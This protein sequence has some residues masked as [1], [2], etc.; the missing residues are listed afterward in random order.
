MRALDRWRGQGRIEWRRRSRALFNSTFEGR[1]GPQ[2]LKERNSWDTPP[3]QGNHFH[4]GLSGSL[5]FSATGFLRPSKMPCWGYCYLSSADSG[6]RDSDKTAG[7]LCWSY[8]S[9]SASL[10]SYLSCSSTGDPRRPSSLAPA[11]QQSKFASSGETRSGGAY[12]SSSDPAPASQPCWI[13]CK[14]PCWAS[15]HFDPGYF[16]H[17]ELF[18]DPT[19]QAPSHSSSQFTG[20]FQFSDH[21]L[22]Q[23]SRRLSSCCGGWLSTSHHLIRRSPRSFS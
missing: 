10:R 7:S 1:N 2:F 13:L 20:T 18:A 15:W 11:S 22:A 12:L 16:W 6:T 21:F 17:A 3:A 8:C 14:P 5:S 23:R 19:S 4:S 9:S